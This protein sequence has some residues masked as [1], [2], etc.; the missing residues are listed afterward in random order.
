MVRLYRRVDPT[1]ESDHQR[2]SAACTGGARLVRALLLCR[3]RTGARQL[4]GNDELFSLF[5]F[6][7]VMFDS[8]G[9]V[10]QPRWGRL[11]RWRL[12]TT[13]P[14]VR[15]LARGPATVA[16]GSSGWQ[17]SPS[18]SAGSAGARRS[19]ELNMR[20]SKGKCR[21]ISVSTVPLV[22]RSRHLSRRLIFNLDMGL[23]MKG[24]SLATASA[25]QHRYAR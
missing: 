22:G 3:Q 14:P 12:A 5:G 21:L 15:L 2:G 16:V 7:N 18:R 25:S 17:R 4:F 24:R 9:C 19:C 23:D 6:G 8:V 10:Q 1:S 11:V 13:F 20:W